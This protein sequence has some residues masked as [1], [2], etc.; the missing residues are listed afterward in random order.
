MKIVVTAGYRELSQMAAEVVAEQV[1]SNKKSVL[2]LAT[3]STP[4]GMYAILS[5]MHQL[6]NLDFSSVTTF[7][8][9]E[10][11]SLAPDHPQSY[12]Y[13]MK[14]HFFDNVNIKK[15]NINI[16]SVEKGNPEKICREYDQKIYNTGQIDL[17]VLGI[18]TN[19]HIGFNEP[20]R[21]LTVDTHLVE[22]TEET[23]EANSRFFK[24]KNDVPN[25]AITMGL[26][27]IMKA[28]R[29]MLLAFGNNKANAVKEMLSGKV[30]TEMP[31]SFLQLHQNLLVI[32][33]HD[34]ASLLQPKEGQILVHP[35]IW[36]KDCKKKKKLKLFLEAAPVGV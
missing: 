19:G 35:G 36:K 30:T 25:R 32:L 31:A 23:I 4:E 27:S 26:G 6:D 17:Q 3:G 29:I 21:F 18:G 7:N 14:H 11:F 13:Y 34:A 12:H 1:R 20:N 15:S 10:Y 9:D 28:K 2:G 33:D 5:K 24:S 16:P 22:L 8:L